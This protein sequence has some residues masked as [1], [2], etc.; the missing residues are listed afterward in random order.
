M[1]TFDLSVTFP[2][3]GR[4]VLQSRSLF[5][6]VDGPTCRRFL[7][8]VFQ[9]G[10]VSQVTIRGGG[11]PR[12]ELRYCARTNTLRD[13]VNRVVGYL[14]EG[15]NDQGPALPRASTARDRRGVVRYHRHGTVVT[16]WSI[17]HEQPGRLRLRNPVLDRKPA[18]CR[19]IE[20]SLAHVAGIDHVKASALTGTARVDFD[21]RRLEPAQ[22]FGVLDAALTE[23]DPPP[24]AARRDLHL[25]LC[26]ASL[27]IAAAAQLAFPPLL[28]LAAVLCTY[29][30]IPTLRKASDVLLQQRRLGA[31]VLDALVVLGC[32]GTM[33]VL[34][35]AVLCW[36][37]SVGQTLVERTHEK[38]RKLLLSHF[39]KLPAHAWLYREDGVEIRVATDRL[40]ADD[41]IVVNPGEV[42]PADGHVVGGLGLVDQHALTGEPTTTEKGVGDRVFAS[43]MLIAGRV[44]VSVESVG[45]TTAASRLGEALREAAGHK[46]GSQQTGE[47][48]ADQ[49]VAP[50]LALGT[51]GAATMGLPGGLAILKSDLGA[52][53]RTAAPL[54][55]LSALTLCAHRGIIVQ[56]GRAL[57]SVN[58]IDTILF[59]QAAVRAWE[60]LEVGRVVATDDFAPEDVLRLAATAERTFH[61]PIARAILRKADELELELLEANDLQYRVGHGVI[62]K[63][64]GHTVRVGSRRLIEKGGVSLPAELETALHEAHGQGA[65]AIFVGVDD[66]AAGMIELLAPLRPE[67]PEVIAELRRSGVKRFAVVSQGHHAATAGLAE[68]LGVDRD[69]TEIPPL[70]QAEAVA[71]LRKEGS[72]VGF[73]GDGNE[74]PALMRTADLSIS[75][76]GLSSVMADAADVVFLENDLRRLC[77]FREVARALDRNMRRSR[78]LV[79]APNIA[80]MAGVFTMGFGIMASVVTNNVAALAALANGALPLRRVA[81]AE[82]ERQHRLDLAQSCAPN[83]AF[84]DTETTELRSGLRN[85]LPQPVGSLADDLCL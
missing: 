12:A 63:S 23:N 26:T 64:M 19:A 58:E 42:V 33:S 7:S 11:H 70:E 18:L 43:T 40:R 45:G 52:G 65:E 17:Q 71:R 61:H 57:E 39:G 32:L 48:L 13:V 54:A 82:A 66:R 34:P 35:G 2:A 75:L 55:L 74:N 3:P 76:K 36:C 30:A 29:T 56:R 4:I 46:L 25:P 6:D 37:A 14:R 80:C 1:S 38:S 69:L 62:V 21:P 68:S 27:P 16:G 24:V 60:Q 79:L 59:D 15:A 67:L 50:T 73:V 41:V 77:A 20:R 53:V 9:A 5:E 47:R 83:S 8:R 31:D 72:K 22:V 84:A 81:L 51:L 44:V 78:S 28:P 85:P 49:A 10:E